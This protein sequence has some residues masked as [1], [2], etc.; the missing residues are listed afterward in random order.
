ME[1]P[2]FQAKVTPL[3]G[4]KARTEDLGPAQGGAPS[5]QGFRHR[6]WKFC[7]AG[8]TT[9][10]RLSPAPQAP[11]PLL[12]WIPSAALHCRPQALSTGQAPNSM[13][14]KMLTNSA[15]H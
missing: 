13:P 11:S 3:Q 15:D 5:P 4:E 8:L 7:S 14:S 2:G 9:G 10:H 1:S 12:G 6:G